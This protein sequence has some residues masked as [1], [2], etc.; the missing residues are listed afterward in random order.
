MNIRSLSKGFFVNTANFS[1]LK[2][3]HT[4]HSPLGSVMYQ[5]DMLFGHT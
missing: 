1:K 5:M 2:L 4:S 3:I